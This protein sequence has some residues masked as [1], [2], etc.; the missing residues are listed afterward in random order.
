MV[1]AMGIE[2]TYAAWE[3][4]VLPLNYARIF[5]LR[6]RICKSRRGYHNSRGPNQFKSDK[7]HHR[8]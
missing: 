4:N 2:P 3:A 1:R 6:Q 8:V 7:N 5:W